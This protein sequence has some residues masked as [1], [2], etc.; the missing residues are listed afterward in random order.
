MDADSLELLA[1]QLAANRKAGTFSD[2]PMKEIRSREDAD[3]VQATALN[4]YAN[5]VKGYAL[6]GTSELCRRSLGLQQPIF[7]PIADT[8]YFR[9]RCHI[10]LP[11]GIIGAQSEL[12]FTMGAMPSNVEMISRR[13][14][15][16]SVLAC[17]P[18]IG[19]LGRRTRS[20]P[21]ADLD[22]IA[23]FGLHVATICGPYAT[24]L[25]A[26]TLDQL[27][28]VARINGKSVITAT[29]DAV[30]GHPLDALVWLARELGR[31]GH[32]LSAG[33]IVTTGSV[34]PVLQVLPG[35]HLVVEWE[36]VGEASC[37]FD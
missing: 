26:E 23:D 8:S 16:D 2:L 25:D 7:V 9:D 15:A 35:Q 5:D 18:A 14:I 4:R 17:Q 6:A 31:Q 11:E 22:A 27:H 33:D 20:S 29:G 28:M 37:W 13:A 10:P 3:I 12:A 24:K 21:Y 34:E 36:M 32:Y 1:S 30:F 19:L